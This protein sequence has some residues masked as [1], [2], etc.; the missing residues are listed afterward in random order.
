[1]KKKKKRQDWVFDIFNYLII[2][3]ITILC[4]F[5]FYYVFI[6][7]ISDAKLAEQGI[8]LLP[9]GFSLQSYITLFKLNDIP[10]AIFIYVLISII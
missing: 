8:S 10:H 7:S 6:Y 1:M 9:K 5:P 4:I 3:I 2:G